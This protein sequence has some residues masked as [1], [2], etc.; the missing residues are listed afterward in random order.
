MSKK[1]Q[2]KTNCINY[3]FEIKRKKMKKYL[4]FLTAFAF[5]ACGDKGN[6]A[7]ANIENK[8]LN[9]EK[10]IIAGK[11]FIPSTLQDE[12]ASITFT[13]SSYNGFAG[14]NRFFGSFSVKGDKISFADNGGATRMMCPPEVMRFENALLT[15]LRGEFTLSKENNSYILKSNEIKIYL[16]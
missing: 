13:Q 1:E 3:K 10:L 5:L 7:F 9:I 12:N 2:V 15:H 8:H 6:V 4:L 16:K 11:N 14:C